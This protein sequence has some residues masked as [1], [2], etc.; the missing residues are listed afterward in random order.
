[1]DRSF[2]SRIIC[3]CLLLFFASVAEAQ[4]KREKE[5]HAVTVDPFHGVQ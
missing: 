1:M 5:N 2:S 4:N 3:T